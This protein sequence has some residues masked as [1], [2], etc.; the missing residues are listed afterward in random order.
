MKVSEII[1]FTKP[2]DK[3]RFIEALVRAGQYGGKDKESM[4]NIIRTNYGLN[5]FNEDGVFIP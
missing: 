3:V 4:Y 5:D 2:K 1:D